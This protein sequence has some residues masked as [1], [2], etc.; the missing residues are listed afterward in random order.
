[1]RTTREDP[2]TP[3]PLRDGTLNETQ[4]EY[5]AS[6]PLASARS[7]LPSIP[8]IMWPVLPDLQRGGGGLH[9]FRDGQ[10]GAIV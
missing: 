2:P 6:N 5:T 7:A 9:P 8:V 10:V 1:M 3:T 4:P